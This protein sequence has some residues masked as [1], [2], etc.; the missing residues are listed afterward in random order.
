MRIAMCAA[1]A[2]VIALT[3]PQAPASGMH[4]KRG[5]EYFPLPKELKIKLYQLTQWNDR[6]AESAI[7]SLMVRI[8]PALSN[9]YRIIYVSGCDQGHRG[10]GSRANPY[11]TIQE[12]VEAARDGD[13]VVVSEGVYEGGVLIEKDILLMGGFDCDFSDWN[14]LSHLTVIDRPTEE[15]AAYLHNLLVDKGKLNPAPDGYDTAIAGFMFVN[16]VWDYLFPYSAVSLWNTRSLI[17][18]NLFCFNNGDCISESASESSIIGNAFYSNVFGI[19]S[20]NDSAPVIKENVFWDN[21]GTAIHSLGSTPYI[22]NNSFERTAAGRV[23]EVGHSSQAPAHADRNILIS[24]NSISGTRRTEPTQNAG[25]VRVGNIA[26]R[27]LVITHNRIFDNEGAGI[28]IQNMSASFHSADAH[29]V[30]TDNLIVCNGIPCSQGGVW[31]QGPQNL[32]GISVTFLNFEAHAHI[33]HNTVDNNSGIGIS[34]SAGP[35]MHRQLNVYNNIITENGGYWDL[36]I[37]AGEGVLRGLREGHNVIYNVNADPD[38]QR[39]RKSIVGHPNP[40]FMDEDI[41]EEPRFAMSS[42]YTQYQ[43]YLDQYRSPAVDA[44]RQNLPAVESEV[45]PRTTSR[46]NSPDSGPIDIGYHYEIGA[47]YERG[48]QLRG[49]K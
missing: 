19:R 11:F 24:H 23:I 22:L 41:Y 46:D 37:F 27:N 32:S 43:Y 1:V 20:G 33:L 31:P 4:Q 26:S 48:N 34:F 8:N 14:P 9:Q 30:L 38:N 13:A 15:G 2:C 6:T 40:G 5:R 35:H 36:R 12:G 45:R 7:E 25:A 39:S 42:S 47:N 18:Y 16:S 10:D 28:D 17:T 49:G 29:I 3:T 44:G 21:E